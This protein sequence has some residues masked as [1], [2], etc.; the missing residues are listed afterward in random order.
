MSRL[1]LKSVTYIAVAD[2]EGG[3]RGPDQVLAGGPFPKLN[4]FKID[5]DCQNIVI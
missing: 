3:V 1:Y 5:Q 4:C 2:P